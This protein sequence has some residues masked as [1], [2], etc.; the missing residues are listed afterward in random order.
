MQRYWR[1][2]RVATVTAGS[3]QIQ[4]TVLARAV[5]VAK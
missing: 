2:A 3:S 4:R 1:E 5:G